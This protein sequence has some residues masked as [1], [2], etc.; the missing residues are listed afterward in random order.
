[1]FKKLSI[2]L[3]AALLT[4]TSVSWPHLPT[5]SA[6]A[7]YM[8]V[9]IPNGGKIINRG[10]MSSWNNKI[11]KFEAN[12]F[13]IFAAGAPGTSMEKEDIEAVGV[14]HVRT[15]GAG[16]FKAKISVANNP[17][18]RRLAEGG[19]ARMLLKIGSIDV[20]IGGMNVR[21]DVNGKEKFNQF[22]HDKSANSSWIAFGPNDTIEITLFGFFKS[23]SDIELYFADITPPTYNGNT[24]THTGVV[25]FNGDPAVQKNELFLKQG[26]S[27]N[28]A[29]NFSEPVFPST[30][31]N[32]SDRID[33]KFSFMR[34][35]TV[36]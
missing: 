34:T 32:A 10:D 9:N 23:A 17:T 11:D 24:L 14:S 22:N 28:L 27:L 36:Q 33:G 26:S 18:L 4:L 20:F 7:E 8:D 35:E 5:V 25:R 19:D 6:A 15:K 1:M 12:S 2:C 3:L 16:L 13:G 21:V 29:L 31:E 30:A